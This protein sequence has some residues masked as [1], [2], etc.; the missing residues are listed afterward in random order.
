MSS[1]QDR[2]KRAMRSIVPADGSTIGN[3]AL[4][5]EIEALLQSEGLSIGEDDYWQAHGALVAEGVLLK[6]QGRGGSVR[7]A[8]ATDAN[9]PPPAGDPVRAAR[10][11]QPQDKTTMA[12]RKTSKTSKTSNT[13]RNANGGSLGFEAELFKAADK[14]RGNMEPSDYKHV[15]LGLIF[16]KYISDAFEAKHT[17]LLAED[18][19]AA[20]DKDEYLADN[21]FWVPKEARWSHLQASAKQPTIGTLI[22]EAMRAIE[23]DNESLKGVLPK[24]YARPA[25]NKVMLGELVDLISG[26]ALGEA[27]DRSKDILG[28]VYEYFLGQFAGAEG[29]RGGEFYTPRSVVRVLVEMLEPLPDP[30]RGVAG[31]VYDPCCGSGGMFVQSEKFVQEHGG[32]IGDIAIYG[33]ESN[34]TTW[35]LAK[36]NLAVRGIDS[37]IRWNNEGSFHKDELRDL[38]ADFILAN[39]PFNISDWGGDR[40]REDLRWKFGA[41]PAGNANYAWLQHI[42]HHLAPN[43]TAGVVLANGSMSSNQSGEGEIRRAMVEADVVDCMVALPGQL[44]YSTQIPACLW[45]LARNKNPE[46]GK[47]GGLRDRRGQVLFI[48]ARKL[49]VLVDRTRRELTDE[50]VQKIAGTYHAWRG[51]AGAGEYADVA[52]FCK[53]ATLEE[54]R[55]HGHVLTPGRYVGAAEQ[56]EDGE[57]LEEKMARLAA[58][59]RAQRAEAA[60]LDAAIEANL[61][62]LGYGG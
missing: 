36:M 15:A 1:L 4:R 7:R 52:G 37:D 57:P 55:K 9:A 38:K 60:R 58:Q 8:Q 13:G 41:P 61:R 10:T 50:E 23:K 18:P 40:L 51:E 22:D 53:S 56:E 19:Q 17:A 48:D 12:Q 3:T 49:G 62:E 46:H 33:Q 16:L 44:F 42:H 30:A 21:V 6:G 2:V 35:R 29:K 5:R 34:Y 11:V 54:I 24:D 45:F 47:P 31:R 25:L 27:G 32:R 43:G 26:I 20:E 39:P 14:L 59:W 28:R